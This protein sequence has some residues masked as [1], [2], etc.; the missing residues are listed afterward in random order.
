M[1]HSGHDGHKAKAAETGE[2]P[3]LRTKE[4]ACSE[5]WSNC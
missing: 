2:E 1:P 4:A 5:D 3:V